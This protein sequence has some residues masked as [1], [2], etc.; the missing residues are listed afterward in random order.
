MVLFKT[1]NREAE[2]STKIFQFYMT[3]ERRLVHLCDFTLT[4]IYVPVDDDDSVP[5][6]VSVAVEVDDDNRKLFEDFEKK[7]QSLKL[8]MN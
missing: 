4:L 5:V 6:A 7:L 8:T 3:E 2:K 1:K